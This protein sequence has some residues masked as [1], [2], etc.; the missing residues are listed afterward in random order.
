MA[1]PTSAPYIAPAKIAW[2]YCPSQ[3]PQSRAPLTAR[4][5]T[6]VAPTPA[7]ISV[8]RSSCPPGDRRFCSDKIRA[9]SGG[10]RKLDS[11]NLGRDVTLIG[12][13]CRRGTRKEQSGRPWKAQKVPDQ[14]KSFS[15]LRA[16]GNPPVFDMVVSGSWASRASPRLHRAGAERRR[17]LEHAACGGAVF[18]DVQGGGA[19]KRARRFL[20]ASSC[21][22]IRVDPTRPPAHQCAGHVSSNRIPTRRS[23]ERSESTSRDRFPAVGS[24]L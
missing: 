11:R 4:T 12:G 14:L 18:S 19:G 22:V 17:T 24:P 6:S 1:A 7:P 20:A 8:F 15:G 23:P 16:S 9:A 10:L 21:R 13:L 5:P 2:T 3:L